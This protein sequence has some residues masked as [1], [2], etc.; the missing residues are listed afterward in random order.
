M[1]EYYDNTQLNDYKTCP[2][3]YYLRHIKGWR[4]KGTSMALIFGLSWH[5]AMDIIWRGFGQAPDE[6][7]VEAAM[8]EFEKCWV[9]SGA[10]PFTEIDLQAQELLG[11]RTPMT[12]KEMLFAYIEL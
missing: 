8:Q 5:A 10:K 2:R 9:E 4:A 7:L 3:L 11:A 1:N 12:A 6:V